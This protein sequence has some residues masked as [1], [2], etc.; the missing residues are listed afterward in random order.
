[1]GEGLIQ[2][3]P[4][5]EDK[6]DSFII[7]AF[8]ARPDCDAVTI[9]K[10]HCSHYVYIDSRPISCIRGT[11]KTIRAMYNKYNQC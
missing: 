11:M 7:D 6:S 10:N 1:M 2:P 3:A 4:S 9:F 8:I 5:N